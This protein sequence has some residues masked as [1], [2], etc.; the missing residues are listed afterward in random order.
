MRNP[1]DEKSLLMS[2][3]LRSIT[4]G[5]AYLDMGFAMLGKILPIIVEALKILDHKEVIKII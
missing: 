2:D 4:E 3:N 1:N 5:Y